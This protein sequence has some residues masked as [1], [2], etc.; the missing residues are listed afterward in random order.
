MTSSRTGPVGKQPAEIPEPKWE[1]PVHPHIGW[2]ENT[3]R[4]WALLGV[5]TGQMCGSN[6]PGEDS[7]HSRGTNQN[8]QPKTN[9]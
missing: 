6:Y 9:G 2:T 7:E 3:R 1:V 4:V 5:V 8:K